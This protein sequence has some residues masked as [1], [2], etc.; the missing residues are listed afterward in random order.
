MKIKWSFLTLRAL[1]GR[2]MVVLGIS[3]TAYGIFMKFGVTYYYHE[4]IQKF[5]E[6]NA[7]H[8]TVTMATMTPLATGG[9]LT[10]QSIVGNLLLVITVLSHFSSLKI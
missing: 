5:E 1:A 6:K 4:N 9:S 8:M 7:G 3:I 10:A 2:Q